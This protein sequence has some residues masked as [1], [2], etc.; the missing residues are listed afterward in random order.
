MSI[1]NAADIKIVDDDDNTVTD[2]SLPAS[3]LA[4]TATKSSINLSNVTLAAKS[5]AK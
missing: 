1:A 2:M 3:W 4:M 5:Y